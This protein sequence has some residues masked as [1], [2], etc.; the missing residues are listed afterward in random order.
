MWKLQQNK[1]IF[2][3]PESAD[4]L[5]ETH[6]N[7]GNFTCH[8]ILHFHIINELYLALKK[9]FLSWFLLPPC[10]CWGLWAGDRQV[11]EKGPMVH[12]TTVCLIQAKTLWLLWHI[13]NSFFPIL[14]IGKSRIGSNERHRFGLFVC[15]FQSGQ[16][17]LWL[18]GYS[19]N[20]VL[21]NSKFARSCAST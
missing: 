10:H 9:R 3:L 12:C 11:Q 6:I 20:T 1:R 16:S 8:L 7:L 19:K 4:T 18:I 2:I 15:F 17:C 5:S 13:R 21:A 14:S